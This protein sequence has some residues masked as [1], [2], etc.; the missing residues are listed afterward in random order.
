MKER[1]YTIYQIYNKLE[2][3]SYIGCTYDL[4]SRIYSHKKCIYKGKQNWKK[5]FAEHPENWQVNIL[6]DN[7][8]DIEASQKEVYYIDLYDAIDNGYNM[9]RQGN[10][11]N[12][13]DKIKTLKTSLAGHITTNETK[14]KISKA[15]KGHTVSDETKQKISAKNKGRQNLKNSHPLTEETKKKISESLKGK[16]AWNKGKNLSEETKQ[17]ISERIKGRKLSEEHRK[18]ISESNKGRVFLEETI[19]KISESNKGKRRSEETRKKLSESH[20][21]KK[22][23]EETIKKMKESQLKRWAK[24]KN[25]ENINI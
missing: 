4:E 7:V 23:P 25:M 18:K 13:S 10:T 6:E 21:G 2:N 14:Q 8:Q 22:L 16:S 24:I 12:S 1:T 11:L 15:L 20:K 19:K 3:K 9:R 5:D 17:K